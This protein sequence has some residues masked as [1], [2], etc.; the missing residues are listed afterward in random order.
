MEPNASDPMSAAD[1]LE[2]LPRRIHEVIARHVAER[3]DH[4]A[5]VEPAATW[6]YR[7]LADAVDAVAD[8]F[9]GLAIR[10]GDRV[11]LASENSAALAAFVFA[12]SKLGAWPVVANPRLSPRELDQIVA[13][14]GARRILLAAA[15]SKEAA[16]HGMRLG[17]ERRAVGPF[18]DIAI[19]AL[20]ETAQPEPVETTPPARSALSCTPRGLR[21]SPKE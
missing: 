18:A 15:V 20:N 8:D 2:G 12:C 9:R 10:P 13:H 1:I 21:A 7:A 17:A 19:G 11:V 5:L 16:D 4:P 6:S 3:P 14:S